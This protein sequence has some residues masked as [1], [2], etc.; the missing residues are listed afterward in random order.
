MGFSVR[1]CVGYIDAAWR[2]RNRY[3]RVCYGLR[4]LRIDG[5][6]DDWITR[7]E[8]HVDWLIHFEILRNLANIIRVPQCP[9]Q[10][11]IRRS[12]IFKR[13]RQTLFGSSLGRVGGASTDA[14]K[15]R[16][17]SLC[18][19]RA[20]LNPGDKL[21][22]TQEVLTGRCLVLTDSAHVAGTSRRGK[23]NTGSVRPAIRQPHRS[24]FLSPLHRRKTI[25]RVAPTVGAFC[26][27]KNGSLR[28]R[29]TGR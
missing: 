9:P 15:I 6:Y 26:V 16:D 20:G 25:R 18:F 17:W 14:L 7:L 5:T 19:R 13:S 23:F 22:V 11:C 28:S 27:E 29:K 2:T 21:T 8:C 24:Q 10:C 3:R 1:W 12:S 4:S